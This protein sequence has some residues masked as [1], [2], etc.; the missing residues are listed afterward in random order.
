MKRDNKL[1]G[2]KNTKVSFLSQSRASQQNRLLECQNRRSPVDTE[3]FSNFCPACGCYLEFEAWSRLSP[4][5]KCANNVEFSL[6]TMMLLVE[7]QKIVKIFTKIG[8]QLGLS[9]G[10]LGGAK[11]YQNHQIG[12]PGFNCLEQD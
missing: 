7:I 6:D 11:E 4:S 9:M 10:A 5:M 2:L 8:G 1:G 3:N 12:I